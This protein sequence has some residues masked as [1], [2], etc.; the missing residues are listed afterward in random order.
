MGGG[1]RIDGGR[2]RAGAPAGARVA[3]LRKKLRKNLFGKGFFGV[4]GVG[5]DIERPFLRGRAQYL[6]KAK[7]VSG[8]RFFGWAHFSLGGIRTECLE[9][10]S[11]WDL[12]VC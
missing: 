5:A 11:N 8:E 4:N 1:V 10:Y 12:S 2:L 7:T 6:P 9:K 3:F